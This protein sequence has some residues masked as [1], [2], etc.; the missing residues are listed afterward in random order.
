MAS[1]I[2]STLRQVGLATGVAVLGSIFTA[3]MQSVLPQSQ[4]LTTPS[5]LRAG[6]A[7]GMNRILL[8]GAVVALVSAVG[9]LLLI[10]GRDFVTEEAVV[11]EPRMPVPEG[12]PS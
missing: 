5:V 12:S 1:G 10:R 4:S 2:N 8:I 6:F 7:S 9:S 11:A 3:R